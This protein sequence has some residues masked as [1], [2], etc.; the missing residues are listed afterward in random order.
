[1][2]EIQDYAYSVVDNIERY[3]L[4]KRNTKGYNAQKIYAYFLR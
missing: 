1:M 3:H 2:T 4:K